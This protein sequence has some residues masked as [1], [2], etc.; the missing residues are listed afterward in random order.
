MAKTHTYRHTFKDGSF[1]VLK[2][3]L[4]KGGVKIVANAA[5]SPE[6]KAEYLRWR[7]EVVVPDIVERLTPEQLKSVVLKGL[8]TLN[9]IFS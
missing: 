1:I 5:I 8:K 7:N 9:Q 2:A 4:N 3:S 6:S